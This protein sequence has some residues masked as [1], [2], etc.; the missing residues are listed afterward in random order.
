MPLGLVLPLLL[1]QTLE[2]ASLF[3]DG[4][5]HASLLSTACPHHATRPSN[6][7]AR[8]GSG[9]SGTGSHGHDPDAAG[10]RSRDASRQTRSD[11]EHSAPEECTC[12][13]TGNSLPDGLILITLGGV[14]VPVELDPLL[15]L[16]PEATLPEVEEEDQ[17]PSAASR[18]H[19]H[20]PKPQV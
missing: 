19:D 18:T 7:H 16:P 9:G 13:R 14:G 11:H 2:A 8:A 5:A 20:P 17:R 10:E 4:L 3:C 15:N 1:L 6:P 12:P